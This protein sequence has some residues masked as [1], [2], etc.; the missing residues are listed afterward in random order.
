MSIGIH[1]HMHIYIYVHVCMHT[2]ICRKTHK[3]ILNFQNHAHLHS[4]KTIFIIINDNE[5]FYTMSVM[6]RLSVKN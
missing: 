5:V 6:S 4:I 1:E 2:H 3:H